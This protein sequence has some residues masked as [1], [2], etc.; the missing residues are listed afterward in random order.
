MKLISKAC[1]A[2]VASEAVAFGALLPDMLAR[3]DFWTTRPAMVSF[4]LHLPAM[5]IAEMVAWGTQPFRGVMECIIAFLLTAI[6]WSFLWLL[7]FAVARLFITQ[8]SIQAT[9]ANATAPDLRRSAGS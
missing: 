6:L 8:P 4:L 2:G 3:H 9:V 1:L 5:C 7:I